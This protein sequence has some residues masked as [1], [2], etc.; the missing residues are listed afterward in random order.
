MDDHVNPLISAC[1]HRYWPIPIDV[2]HFAI[3]DAKREKVRERR[4]MQHPDP[5]DP[6]HPEDEE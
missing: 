5:H 3:E 2:D 1:L 4:L 6:D